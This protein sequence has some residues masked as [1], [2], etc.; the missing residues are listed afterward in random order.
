MTEL[1]VVRH[2]ETVW[3][4]ENRYAGRSD[5]ALTER[6]E[7]QAAALADWA[8]RAGLDAVHCS[9]LSR[10]VITATAVGTRIGLTPV[11]DPRLLELDFGECDGLTAAEMPADV[12]KRFEADPVANHLPGGEHPADAAKRFL[13]GLADAVAAHPGGRVLVV[14]HST[15][16]RLA[17]CEMLGIALSRYRTVFPAIANCRGAR[18]RVHKGQFSLLSLNEPL[19]GAAG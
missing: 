6:G 18:L 10:A 5:V 15:A 19:V 8:E 16:L 17:L 2:G 9:T 3:H 12:R 4:K 14:A 7:R 13:D 11:V 1:T